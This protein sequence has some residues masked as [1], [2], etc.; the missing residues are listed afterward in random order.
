MT[1][2]D[3]ATRRATPTVGVL[4][5]LGALLLLAVAGIHGYLWQQGFKNEDIIGPAFLA[6]VVLGIGGALLLLVAP[7]RWL[8]LAAIA[9]ALLCLGTLGGLIISSTVGLFGFH[10]SSSTDLYWE[11][12]VVEIAGGIVLLALAALTAPRRR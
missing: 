5:I 6:N 4:R 2:T 9:G 11:S 3:P 1:R 7:R 8:W 12:V 10:E